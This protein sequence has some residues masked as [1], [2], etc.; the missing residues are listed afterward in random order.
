VNLA[1]NRSKTDQFSALNITSWVSNFGIQM[2][3]LGGRC[4]AHLPDMLILEL[5][6]AEIPQ[7]GAH[8]FK[9]ASSAQDRVH[10]HQN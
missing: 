4:F 3:H 2:H 10:L 7:R 8:F 6:R 1:G 5:S 9:L